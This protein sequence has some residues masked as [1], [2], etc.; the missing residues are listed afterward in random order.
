[1]KSV[2]QE[3]LWNVADVAAYLCMSQSFVY[4][5]AAAGSIPCLRIASSL[6]FD[7]EKV[8]AFARGELEGTVVRLSRGLGL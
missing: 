8:R 2:K 5:A 4:K 7:P 3:P 6:R 1:M